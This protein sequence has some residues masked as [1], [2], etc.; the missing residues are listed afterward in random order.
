MFQAGGGAV[1]AGRSMVTVEESTDMC[2]AA[3]T[4][5]GVCVVGSPLLYA[6]TGHP[7]AGY[8]ASMWRGEG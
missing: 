3:L 2:E 1:V 7:I 8:G 6:C 4:L 5:A